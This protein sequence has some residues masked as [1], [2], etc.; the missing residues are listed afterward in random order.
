M[1]RILKKFK[2]MIVMLCSIGVFSS[3]EDFLGTVPLNEIVL[4]N[5]WENEEEVNSVVMSCYSRMA[6]GDFLT[7][8]IL[9][10]ELRSD[11][12]VEGI[13]TG[14]IPYVNN[15]QLRDMLEGNIQ[16]DYYISDWSS[17]YSVINR[18]NTVLYYAPQVLE[19]D[20]DFKVS[21]WEYIKA[22]MLTL[23][24]LCYFYLVR[25]FRDVPLVL[26]P[27]IDD[28]QEFQV[29][30]ADPNVVLEQLVKDLQEAELFALK[31]FP[32]S[33]TS[34]YSY[35]KARVTKQTVWSLL[36]DIYL[37][38][39]RYDECIVYCEKLINAKI[40]DAE[41]D[42]MNYEGNYPLL[43]NQ[44]SSANNNIHQAFNLIFGS[45]GNSFESIFEMPF[46]YNYEDKRDA[47]RSYYGALDVPI[48]AMTAAT[49]IGEGAKDGNDLYKS[50]DIRAI[51]AFDVTGTSI[52]PIHKY[53]CVNIS[54]NGGVGYAMSR[55]PNWIFY[56][57][58]DVMLMEAEALVERNDSVDAKPSDLQKAFDLASS[59]Y[60]RANLKGEALKFSGE[61]ATQDGLR[62]F[63]LAER[64][65]E[66]MFEGKRW[67]DLVRKARREGSNSAMLDL[68][69]R[70][71][72]SPGTVK[73]KWIKPDMLYLP[74]HEDELKVNPLLKQNPEYITDKTITTAK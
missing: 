23:R 72:T 20:P 16:E 21:E 65:R 74:I 44:K 22:E 33:S 69:T 17:F 2:Y 6:Q 66:L 1:K 27:T 62:K 54:D 56:R 34:L 3:C 48:G 13:I 35:T 68:A 37:W 26:E 14:E 4:E 46:G 49:F 11:N 42:N 53:A 52:Y 43:A 67:F 73:S 64:Q 31:E 15:D 47:L 32:G 40:A 12:V 5:F 18:C 24:A 58:T 38:M 61:L 25:S 19:R 50:S 51:E 30:A 70:K 39:E 41:K 45:Q 29:P 7:R 9:W 36:A 55:Y 63:V 60:H 10:G 57:L 28:S 8:L 59:V 71:Y